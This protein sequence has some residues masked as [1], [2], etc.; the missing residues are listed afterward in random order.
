MEDSPSGEH[1]ARALALYREAAAIGALEE[2]A[3]LKDVGLRVLARLRGSER[4]SMKASGSKLS[5]AVRLT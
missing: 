2:V 3:P 5:C 1:A 4:R